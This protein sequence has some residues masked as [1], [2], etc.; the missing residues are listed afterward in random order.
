MHIKKINK[1]NQYGFT[2]VEIMVGL[3]IGLIAT[4]AIMQTIAAFEGQKRTTVGSADAQLNGNIAMYNIQ[5]QVQMAGYGL[6][7]F[8]ASS[9]KN[10]SPL[11]CNPSTI[12]NDG[13]PAT[14]QVD[15]FPIA[16]TDGGAAGSDQITVRYFNS[17][18]GGLPVNVI[19]KPV[20]GTLFGVENTMGCA[21]GNIA[22]VVRGTTCSAGIVDP[23]ANPNLN[24]TDFTNITLMGPD[25]AAMST[26]SSAADYAR[27]SCLGA[28]NQFVFRINNNQLESN[29][30]PVISDIVSMQAQYG[31][32]ATST[33][34]QITAWVDAT[35]AWVTP[36]I[37]DRNRIRAIR[38]AIVARNGVQEKE[39]V[40]TVAPT[41]WAGGPVIDLSANADWQKYRYRLY[42]MV[43]PLR[44]M[45]WSGQ[46]L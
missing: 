29:N 26:G 5:R 39:N 9:L 25:V 28:L 37:A 44:N 10:D 30:Q 34:N 22:L 42:Q 17:A 8:D 11:K 3:V 32:S 45:T 14:P 13:L 23:V 46:W 24:T 2:L 12:D 31:V 18:S 40:T 6:P 41:T 27:L 21:V 1:V 20:G 43:I 19:S 15:F 7:I 16:I 38:L 4:L 36:S 33:S 35:N